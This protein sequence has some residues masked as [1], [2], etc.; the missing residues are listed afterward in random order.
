MNRDPLLLKITLTGLDISF[1]P[2][3]AAA[4]AIKTYSDT[5]VHSPFSQP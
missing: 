3:I 1:E 5:T 4:D 2:V